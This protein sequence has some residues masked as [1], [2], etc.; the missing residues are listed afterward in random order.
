MRGESKPVPQGRRASSRSQQSSVSMLSMRVGRSMRSPVHHCRPA[1]G[2]ERELRRGAEG[3]LWRRWRQ[4]HCTVGTH[5][6]LAGGVPVFVRPCLVCAVRCCGVLCG[7]RARAAACHVVGRQLRCA[8]APADLQRVSSSSST[9]LT[10]A[11]TQQPEH[12]HMHTLSLTHASCTAPSTR[13]D[14]G[15]VRDRKKEAEGARWSRTSPQRE[16]QRLAGLV[17]AAD[18][19]R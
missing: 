1:C 14:D 19:C 5:L 15:A 4:P 16:R 9:P 7:V 18:V 13:S 17:A 8:V 3:G 11:H 12:T 6:L 10:P 2:E